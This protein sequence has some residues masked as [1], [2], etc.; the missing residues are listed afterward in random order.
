MGELRI[1][2]FDLFAA[3]FRREF[4]VDH[5]DAPTR[6]VA[7]LGFDSLAYLHLQV[8]LEEATGELFPDEIGPV[9]VTVG[10]AYQYYVATVTRAALEH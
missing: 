5:V 9:I 7:D 2:S 1:A 4:D 3:A 6:L 8:L 10:D